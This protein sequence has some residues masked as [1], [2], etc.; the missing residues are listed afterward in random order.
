MIHSSAPWE[1]SRMIRALTYAVM[2]FSEVVANVLFSKPCLLQAVLF[3]SR[4][5]IHSSAP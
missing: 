1:L 3:S 2:L 4:V 5:G